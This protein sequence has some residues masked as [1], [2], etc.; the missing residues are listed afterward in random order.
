MACFLGSHQ[1]AIVPFGGFEECL[2]FDDVVP[3]LT[4]VGVRCPTVA[5]AAPIAANGFVG[6]AGSCDCV[7]QAILALIVR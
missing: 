4:L 3:S 2:V 6:S 7:V 1:S 5:H